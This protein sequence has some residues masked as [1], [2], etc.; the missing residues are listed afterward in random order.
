MN[1]HTLTKNLLQKITKTRG[2]VLPLFSLLTA[3][4]TVPALALD[5]GKAAP[6]FNLPG[7]NRPIQL[8]DYKGK[9]V[10]LDFWAS[11]C[12]PCKQSFPWMNALQEKYGEKDFKVVAINLDVNTEDWK[13]FLET[14]PA[15]FD[16]ALDPKG[17]IA[18]Q[19]GVKGMPTSLIIDRE[20]KVHVQHA[21]YNDFTKAKSEQILQNLL[22][23][24]K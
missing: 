6:D 5:A 22:G 19:F 24:K 7:I 11:W 13:K 2:I 4:I 10:Y 20:G 1:I 15:N 8:S 21:G 3:L 14:V 16:I 12:G 17:L 18:K 9:V 23:A